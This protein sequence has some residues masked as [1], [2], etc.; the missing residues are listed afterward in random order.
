VTSAAARDE[1]PQLDAERDRGGDH[2]AGQ[3]ATTHDADNREASGGAFR[4]GHGAP[5]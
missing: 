1:H 4:L 2:H 3:L 5:A